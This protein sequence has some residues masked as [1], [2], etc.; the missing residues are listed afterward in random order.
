MI[1]CVQEMLFPS[2]VISL[3]FSNLG[4]WPKT[5]VADLEDRPGALDRDH[6]IEVKVKLHLGVDEFEIFSYEQLIDSF[7]IFAFFSVF[8]TIIFIRELI[9]DE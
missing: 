3:N 4:L 1:T 9:S 5:T 2:L 7:S 6:T 8:R